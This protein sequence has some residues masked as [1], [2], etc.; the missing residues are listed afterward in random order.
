MGYSK[1]GSEIKEEF[2]RRFEAWKEEFYDGAKIRKT[3]SNPTG[4]GIPKG[5]AERGFRS[6]MLSDDSV[7]LDYIAKRMANG[8]SMKSIMGGLGGRVQKLTQG[9]LSPYGVDPTDSMHHLSAHSGYEEAMRLQSPKVLREFLE[10]SAEEGVFYGETDLNLLGGSVNPRSH[11]GHRGKPGKKFNPTIAGAGPD[12]IAAT[13]MHPRGDANDPFKLKP[14]KY[15]SGREMFDAAL[16]I[17]DQHARDAA[18]GLA[19]D[20]SRRNVIRQALANENITTQNVFGPNADLTDIKKAQKFLQSRPDVMT[21]AAEAFQPASLDIVSGVAKIKVPRLPGY[22]KAGGILTALGVIGD[23]ASAAEGG[24]GVAT[25]TGKEQTSA[26]LN[27]ASGVLGL[28]SLAAPPL[29]A[30]SVATGVVGALAENRIERDKR[31][32]RDT[33][34]KAG[35]IQPTHPDPYQTQI[36]APQPST[37]EKITSDPLNE[38][39]Y[40]GNQVMKF[41]GGALRMGS[42][43][44]F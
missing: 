43:A 26:G 23:A 13:S 11:V 10:I 18:V 28:A 9:D 3:P 19:S 35:R 36:T 30:A 37:L 8:S 12:G 32:E 1:E 22:L 16:P 39:Q 31:R 29:T 44:G 40:A 14:Q 25:K 41:F 5:R 17:R 21:A 33:D 4:K 15:A 2:R 42:Q 34:I 20:Q 27:L 7:H 38:L 6:A 24:V